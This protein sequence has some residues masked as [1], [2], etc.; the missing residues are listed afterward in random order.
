V[1]LKQLLLSYPTCSRA[2]LAAAS[3]QMGLTEVRL[4]TSMASA[5]TPAH[6]PLGERA[7]LDVADAADDQPYA[8][9]PRLAFESAARAQQ[10]EPQQA[11]GLQRLPALPQVTPTRDPQELIREIARSLVDIGGTADE[12]DRAVV[13]AELEHFPLLALQLLAQAKRRIVV[14]RNSIVEVMPDLRTQVPRGWVGT[15]KSW[16]DV[17]GV[18]EDGHGRT[19]VA[20]RNGRVPPT[21]DGHNA[22][23]LV[24]HEVAHG[25]DRV[26]S[27]GNA[28]VPNGSNRRRRAPQR[29]RGTSRSRRSRGDLR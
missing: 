14:C 16:A 17:P 15:G 9:S 24:M 3:D 2:I 26:Q 29:V 11:S 21:G 12:A 28:S 27:V 20:I 19:V 13:V 23:N 5:Q 22:I 1:A 4:A 18:G 25:I 6:E 8:G 7:A 10:A